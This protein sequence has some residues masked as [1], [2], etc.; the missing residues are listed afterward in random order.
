MQHRRNALNSAMSLL[1]EFT[2]T[3]V[4][5]R[6]LYVFWIVTGHFRRMA[7]RDREAVEDRF[8]TCSTQRLVDGRIC[9]RILPERGNPLEPRGV[10]PVDFPPSS[11]ILRSVK[12]GHSDMPTRALREFLRTL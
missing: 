5:A 1:I 9:G 6:G 2:V 4:V 12:L 7:A 11:A 8:P 10:F 3:V